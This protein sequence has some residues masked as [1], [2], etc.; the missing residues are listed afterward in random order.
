[1]NISNKNY[2]IKQVKLKINLSAE[3][4]YLKTNNVIN[5]FIFTPWDKLLKSEESG[6]EDIDGKS[7]TLNPLF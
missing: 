1:L 3:N 2:S 5:C 7:L 4:I 6:N